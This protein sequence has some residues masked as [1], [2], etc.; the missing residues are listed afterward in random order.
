MGRWQRTALTEGQLAR[1]TT[2][3]TVLKARAL[4]KE[5]SLP[6]V[7]LWRELRQSDPKFRQQHPIGPYVVDFYCASAKT[8]FEVDGIAHDMGNRPVRDAQRTAW[9]E[10][11]GYRVVHIAARDV[12]AA[13]ADVADALVRLCKGDS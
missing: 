7:L 12:L 8:C 2:R 4:R 11:Q 13:P 9:L 5:R 6:E 3:A 1:Q 10:A